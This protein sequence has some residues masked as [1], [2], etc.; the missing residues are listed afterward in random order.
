[1][2]SQKLTKA[3]LSN[4]LAEKHKNYI[5]EYKKE[6]DIL[7]R[8][9]ILKEKREQLDFWVN[10]SKDN[11]EQHKKYLSAKEAAES[12]F[13]RLTEEL[14]A[15]YSAGHG[16]IG[17]SESDPKGRYKWL[18]GQITAHEEGASYWDNKIKEITDGVKTKGA[19][20]HT[21]EAPGAGTLKTV[22]KVKKTKKV[23][24]AAKTPAKKKE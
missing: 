8:L 3:E 20:D 11:A 7:D 23:V 2:S 18:K 9:A 21:K 17:P 24:K 19:K 13:L 1:M 12:E 15:V 6:Y 10:D 22:K 4:L 14:K 5:K 16:R